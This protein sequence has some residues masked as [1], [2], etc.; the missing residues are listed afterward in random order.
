MAAARYVRTLSYG[1]REVFVD[2][3]WN[4]LGPTTGYDN[5]V[6]VLVSDVL[7]KTLEC[8]QI[9]PTSRRYKYTLL[10]ATSVYLF[11]LIE[12]INVSL[13]TNMKAFWLGVVLIVKLQIQKLG[14]LRG[15]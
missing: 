1:D 14:R 2:C 12:M 6:S 10:S 15:D 8:L 4:Q 5:S 9:I 13:D 7:L 3:I 11:R